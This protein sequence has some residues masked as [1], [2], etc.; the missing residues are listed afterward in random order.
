[1]QRVQNW[2]HSKVG[3][4]ETDKK[5]VEL[6]YKSIVENFKSKH[7]L[8]IESQQ[9]QLEEMKILETQSDGKYKG[10][11]RLLYYDLLTKGVSANT[12]QS[13][14]WT[15]GKYDWI[16]YVKVN[17]P[18]DLQQREGELVKIRTA[19][20]MSR[21]KSTLCHQSDGTTKNLIHWCTC[22]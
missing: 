17:F 21:E 14:V 5:S 7:Q 19:Y 13:V 16:W 2:P 18:A 3:K 1:M 4:Y 6:Y 10:E 9:R 11:V 12:V 22:C 20:E 8:T 15:V